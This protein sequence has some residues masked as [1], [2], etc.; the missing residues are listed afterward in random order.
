MY[1][2]LQPATILASSGSDISMSY[3]LKLNRYPFVLKI[4]KK[5]ASRLM[6]RAHITGTASIMPVMP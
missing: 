3:S 2:N 5:N 1:R 4:V 6:V